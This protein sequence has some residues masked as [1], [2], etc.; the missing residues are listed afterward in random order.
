MVLIFVLITV[1]RTIF[2]INYRNK[3]NN[4]E[5]RQGKIEGI[6][7]K[8]LG[9]LFIIFILIRLALNCLIPK[10][11]YIHYPDGTTKRLGDDNNISS[12]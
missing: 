9:N 11:L 10:K 8:T 4:E 3:M 12:L 6:L 2:S 5:A 1:I 7:W